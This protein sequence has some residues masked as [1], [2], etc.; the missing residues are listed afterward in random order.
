MKKRSLVSLILVCLLMSAPYL[1]GE[2]E[3]KNVRLEGIPEN[4]EDF[5]AIRDAHAVSPEGGA[6]V[7]VLAMI[8]YT[9]NTDLGTDAFTIALDR[10]VLRTAQDGYKG[11]APSSAFMEYPERYLAP[12]PYLAASYISGTDPSTGYK[13]P[14]PPYTVRVL[15]TPYSKLKENEYR[16]LVACSGADSPRP[17]ILK[18]NNRGIWKVSNYSSL[19]V[20]IR[21]PEAPVDDEL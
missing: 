12:R 21:A 1:F 17:V 14:S 9:E 2:E 7:F 13:L 20:G 6:A 18:R 16:V 8:L 4:I 10:S 15:F 11:Y 3:W 19:F 5:L